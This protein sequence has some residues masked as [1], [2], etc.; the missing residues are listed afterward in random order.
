MSRL[1]KQEEKERLKNMLT[2]LTQEMRTK[3]Q[4]EQDMTVAG[5]D[6]HD[7]A[8]SNSDQQRPKK[9]CKPPLH[10][11]YLKQQPQVKEEEVFF[12][13]ISQTPAQQQM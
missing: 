2:Q 8:L 10:N 3:Y 11:N 12:S 13:S 4:I 6:L 5:P 9:L 1:R 7:H